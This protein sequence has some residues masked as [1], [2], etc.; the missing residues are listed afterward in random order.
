MLSTAD[1]AFLL[2]IIF[3]CCE[4]EISCTVLDIHSSMSERNKER[5]KIER[6][7]ER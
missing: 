6:R 2:V 5:K 3:F 4:S 7:K 1:T